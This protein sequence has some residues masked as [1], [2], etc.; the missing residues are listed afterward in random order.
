MSL[1]SGK[2]EVSVPRLGGVLLV[3]LSEDV[4]EVVVRENPA[5]K[6]RMLS[7]KTSAQAPHALSNYTWLPPQSAWRRGQH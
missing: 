5:V 7:L 2:G 6:V 3:R 4:L 1:V